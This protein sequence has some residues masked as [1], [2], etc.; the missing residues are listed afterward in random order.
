MSSFFLRERQAYHGAIFVR[1]VKIDKNGVPNFADSSSKSSSEIARRIARKIGGRVSRRL[2]PT[3]QA[4]GVLFEDLTRVFIKNCFSRLKHL[5]S[6]DWG[7]L[8]KVEI[9]NFYQYA[10]LIEISKAAEDN[11]QLATVLGSDYII[12]PDI[13]VFRKA[14]EDAEINKDEV[15]V[16]GS[17]ATHAPLRKSNAGPPL[18][19]ASVSCKWT[20]RSDR[21]QNSRTEALNLIRNRKG[22]LPHI[23]VVT[24]EPLPGRIAS[25]ALGTGD[26]DCTYH[27]ALY[28]L[29]QAVEEAGLDD[30][31]ELLKTMING[32]RLRDI[33]DLPLDLAV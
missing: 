27:F 14:V 11:P 31:V 3:A 8:R 20:I 9:A 13:V 7:M 33:S 23:M 1:L 5:R 29:V 17:C 18:L 16:D 22:N 32:K 4:S 25:I 12:K 6:G 26:V 30:S 21:S 10:H 2:R 28:E 24:A 19:H 15:L